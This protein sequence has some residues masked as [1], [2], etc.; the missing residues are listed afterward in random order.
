MICKIDPAHQYGC[1]RTQGSCGQRHQP[2]TGGLTAILTIDHP[3]KAEARDLRQNTKGA[4]QSQC[5]PQ[6]GLRS[7]KGFKAQLFEHG[8]SSQKRNLVL[9]CEKIRC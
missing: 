3:A 1:L 7:G 9:L 6:S 2:D 4:S 8:K 5:K